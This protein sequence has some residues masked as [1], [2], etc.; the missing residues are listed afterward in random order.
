MSAVILNNLK[1]ARRYVAR[2]V[3]VDLL[4]FQA[5][6]VTGDLDGILDRHPS[7]WR[8]WVGRIQVHGLACHHEAVLDPV[9]AAQIASELQQ[10][11]FSP[12]G[13]WTM[14]IWAGGQEKAIGTGWA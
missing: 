13:A 7:A 12:N 4:Y 8:P 3:D 5:T 14:E 1:L 11:L 9:P 10:R 6:Q 2:K